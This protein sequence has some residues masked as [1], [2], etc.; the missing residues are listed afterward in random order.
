MTQDQIREIV[1][2]TIDELGCRKMLTDPYSE[3]LRKT[4]NRLYQFFNSEGDANGIGKV[5]KRFSDDA[6]ID[7]IYLQYRDGKTIEW[8]AEAMEK[9]EST[10]LRNKKRIMKQIYESMNDE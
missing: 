4:E 1:K 9:D 2:M 7:V 3:I 10:I 8:I 5:L 6:Y